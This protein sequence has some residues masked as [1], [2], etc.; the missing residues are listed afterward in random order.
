[1]RIEVYAFRERRGFVEERRVTPH[2]MHAVLAR[3][4]ESV[5]DVIER[6]AELDRGRVEACLD[7]EEMTRLVTYGELYLVKERATRFAKCVG[8]ERAPRRGYVVLKL[9]E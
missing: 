6:I 2:D 5:F 1:M 3:H 8:I 7:P 4:I 9:G